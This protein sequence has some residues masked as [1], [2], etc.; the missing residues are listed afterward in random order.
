ME[1]KWI[2]Y[3]KDTRWKK[4]PQQKNRDFL[5]PSEEKFNLVLIPLL[6]IW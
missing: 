1:L 6:I 3:K 2:A 5:V 4:S